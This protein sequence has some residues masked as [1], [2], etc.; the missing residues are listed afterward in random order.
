M[1]K[2]PH[3]PLC[4]VFPQRVAH[5][6]R[7][8]VPHVQ[9]LGHGK[10]LQRHSQ[11]EAQQKFFQEH[12]RSSRNSAVDIHRALEVPPETD[13]H[14]VA[15]EDFFSVLVVLWRPLFVP[16]GPYHA[17][18]VLLEDAPLLYGRCLESFLRL[19]RFAK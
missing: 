3:H 10:V 18:E 7:L 15:L 14:R 16:H 8:W 4:W 11:G 9:C 2:S 13:A 12:P 1:A 5:I 6:V 19:R 17:P